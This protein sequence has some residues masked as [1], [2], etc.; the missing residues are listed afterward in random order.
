ME[1]NVGVGVSWYPVMG[2]LARMTV[3]RK[4]A[5]WPAF[6]GLLVATLIAQIVGMGAA[7]TLGD[8]DPTLWM[9][10]FGGPLLGGAVLLF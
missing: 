6:G 5:V 10:P 8:S 4:A 3:S 7:L 2:S 1:F 9:V